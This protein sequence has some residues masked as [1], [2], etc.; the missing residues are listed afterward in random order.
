MRVTSSRSA[1]A[2]PRA[3]DLVG[4]TPCRPRR[5][6]SRAPRGGAGNIV[7]QQHGG[8]ADVLHLHHVAGHVEVHHVAAVVAVE[9]QHAGAAIGRAHRLRHLVGAGRGEHLA[10]GAGIQQALADIAGEDR[11]MAGAAA[12]DDA[13]LAR[14][15]RA[16]RADDAASAP[17]RS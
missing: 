16:G 9:A 8:G 7:G 2:A 17:V 5:A 11:Q 14:R 1:L 6:A 3:G 12:G 4:D 13:D 10:D 15:R